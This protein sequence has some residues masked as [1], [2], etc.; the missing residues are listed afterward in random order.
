MSQTPAAPAVAPI[1]NTPA[2]ADIS[3]S[4][5]NTESDPAAPAVAALPEAAKEAIKQS[6]KRKYQLQVN[7]QNR[8]LELDFDDEEQVKG[9]LQKALAA[10]S[11]FQEAANLRKSAEQFIDMLRKNPARVLSDPS[12]GIDVKAFAQQ[13]INQE[14]EDM[15]KSPEQRE[16]EKLQ[17]ELEELKDRYKKDDEER[18]SREFQRLQAEAE[19]KI[20]SDI[21][22]ALDTSNL[23]K[24]PYTVK[25]MADLM[26][27]AL[28][29][30]IDL[31][32]KDVVPLLQKQM[33]QEI[34]E[35]LSAANDDVLEEFLDNNVKTRLRKRNVARA[36]E[37]L[38]TA[39]NVRDSGSTTKAKSVEPEQKKFTM[40]EFLSGKF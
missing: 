29:N 28:Q 31:S 32:A 39:T 36:K 24:T 38:K 1:V 20:E 34:R 13:I 23:P 3:E 35:M 15:Q 21:T 16:K 6:N 30:N 25:K 18:K 40:K 33:K 4:S 9:Y 7:K 8:E 27:L 5:E 2:T 12:I 14:I 17:K 19:E 22:G 10:D 26:L 37:A 11:K